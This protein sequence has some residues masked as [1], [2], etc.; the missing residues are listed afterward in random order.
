MDIAVTIESKNRSG[1]FMSIKRVTVASR[2]IVIL[3]VAAV[4]LVASAEDWPEFR[5]PNAQGIYSAKDL[6]L[7]WSKDSNAQWRC[8]LPG[9]GWSSPVV[10]RGKIYLTAAIRRRVLHLR[11]S[12]TS[13]W[14]LFKSMRKVVNC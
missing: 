6:P 2:A 12:K 9:S 5:G 11:I 4:G 3:S 14:F 7:V 13:I 10:V 1:C 8:E